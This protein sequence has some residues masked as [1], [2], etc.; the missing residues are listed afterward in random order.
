LGVLRVFGEIGNAE[1]WLHCVWVCG[2]FGRA[3]GL[4]SSVKCWEDGRVPFGTVLCCGG[5]GRER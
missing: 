5:H 3:R 1:V 4:E 2:M